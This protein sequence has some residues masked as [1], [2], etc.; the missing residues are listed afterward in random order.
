MLAGSRW[1][2][3][4]GKH[5]SGTPVEGPSSAKAQEPLTGAAKLLADAANEEA[6]ESSAMK[7]RDHLVHTQGPI[8]TG[9]ESQYDAVLRM[10]VDAHKPHRTGEG[11]KPDAADKRIKKWMKNLDMSPR[12][13]VTRA[14]QQE[15]TEQQLDSPHHSKIPPHL[16]QPWHATYTGQSEAMTASPKIK[17]GTFERSKIDP[18]RLYSDLELRLERDARGAA[19]KNVLDK[20]QAARL[21]GRLDRAR[22]GAIDYRLGINDGDL[23]NVGSSADV[24]NMDESEQPFRGNRQLRGMSVLGAQRG[25]GSGMRAWGGLVEDRIQVSAARDCP[26]TCRGPRTLVYSTT[27]RAKVLL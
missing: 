8:W 25:S 13:P 17:Y 27:R 11:I 2:A 4:R 16:W 3:Q 21:R 12:V 7:N 5:T 22:E 9:D 14:E 24:D 26:L 20:R 18:D 10:L 23:T 6:E 1:I 19:R 15:P